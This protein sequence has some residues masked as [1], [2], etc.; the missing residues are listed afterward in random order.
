M[1][2]KLT[3][4]AI[5]G[6]SAVRAMFMEATELAAK[7]G[8]ENVYDFSL[9]N[10]A[11]PAPQVLTDA[12]IDIVK[13]EDPLKLH[14]YM[15]NAGHEDVRAAIA[16]NLNK[17]FDTDF[18]AGNII[19]TV[20]AAGALNVV[21][22]TIID[23][24]DE[25]CAFS[26][27]FTEYRNYVRNWQGELVCIEPDYETFMP[28]FA[29]MEKKLTANT[30]AIIINNPVN[31]SGVIYSEDTIK[32]IVDVLKKKQEEYGHEIYIISD[33]PYR[34]LVYGDEKVPFLTKYY[35]NTFVGYSFSKSLSLPGERIGYIA[36]PSEMADF[37]DVM[38]G[39]TISNRVIGFVNAPSIIQ[40]AIVK[41]LDTPTDLEF[42]DTNRKLLYNGLMSLGFDCVKPTGAFYLFLK[43]PEAD[44][45]HFVEVAKK[46]HIMMVNGSTFNCPGYVRLA[47]CLSTES[48]KNSMPA[49]EK[50]AAEYGLKKREDFKGI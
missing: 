28:D 8:A 18:G 48:L 37:K 46:Y 3:K 23:P 22:K 29:D 34:E 33:E 43:S 19:M 25:V 26:P 24:G 7:V 20:G 27:F 30:K 12:L 45:K 31:P 10:P 32:K 5:A 1:I 15:P 40:K 38:D 2:S 6:N 47:Y 41:C 49:F 44:E 4:E 16:A 13:D 17:R 9:G 39:L 35:E 11:T 14:S 36:V 50:L 42:Y 21:L